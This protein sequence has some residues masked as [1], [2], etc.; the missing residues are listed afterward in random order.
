MPGA[1]ADRGV[2][3]RPI[4]LGLV[5][6]SVVGMVAMVPG[7]GGGL[8]DAAADQQSCGDQGEG[9]TRPDCTARHC[10]IGIQ[11]KLVPQTVLSH[12]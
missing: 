8:G 12:V 7:F 11:H 4:A 6:M 5:G 9:R 1:R 2:G 3:V 10:I